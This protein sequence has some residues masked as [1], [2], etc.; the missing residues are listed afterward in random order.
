MYIYI[1][2][3]EVYFH[4]D[5]GRIEGTVNYLEHEKVGSCPLAKWIKPRFVMN[6]QMVSDIYHSA[7]FFSDY[8]VA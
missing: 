1:L 6:P 8:S 5:M 4:Y 2:T 3:R 7:V